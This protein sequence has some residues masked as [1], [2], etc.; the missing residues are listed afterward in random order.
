MITYNT[1]KYVRTIKKNKIRVH[2][3]RTKSE[4]YVV[5]ALAS[6]TIVTMQFK[7]SNNGQIGV[8]SCNTRL[9][10]KVNDVDYKETIND[11]GYLRAPKG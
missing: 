9:V 2:D 8:H 3:T 10:E 7:G 6:H 5:V 11:G 4:C 1:L